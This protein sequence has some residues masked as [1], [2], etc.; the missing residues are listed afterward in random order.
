MLDYALFPQH[1]N[2]V[3]SKVVGLPPESFLLMLS[4]SQMGPLTTM[5]LIA[6]GR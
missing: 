6:D 4:E 5:I 1:V 2:V 3:Q